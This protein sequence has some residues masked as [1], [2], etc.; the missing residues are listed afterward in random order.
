MTKIKKVVILSSIIFI[1]FSLKVFAVSEGEVITY[2]GITTTMPSI[3]KEGI[4]SED[5]MFKKKNSAQIESVNPS[6]AK[7]KA[8]VGASGT[9]EDISTLI[10]RFSNGNTTVVGI[11]VSSWQGDIDWKKVADSGVKFAII[12]CGYRGTSTG[13]LCQDSKFKKNIEGAINNGIFVGVYFY[14]T[15]INESEALQEAATVV[16]LVNGY[17]LKYPISYDFENFEVGG[18]RTDNLSKDQYNKNAK[19]FLDYVASKGYKGS[20]YGSS[21]YLS[22]NWNMSSF[23]NYDTWVAHYYVSNPTYAGKYQLWQYTDRGI[24]PGISEKVDVDIDY[25]YFANVEASVSYLGHIQGIGWENSWRYNGQTSGTTGQ[26][27]RVE[28][29]KIGLSN[30]K[31]VGTINYRSHIEG[32]GWE[33]SWRGDGQVTGTTGQGRRVEAIQVKLTNDMANNYDIYYRVHIEEYGW[34]GWAKNGASAGS[35]GLAKRIE[36]IE[37]KLV[38]KGGAAPGNTSNCFV[39]SSGLSYRAHVQD[40]GWQ[41]Y[42]SEGALSGTTGQSKRMESI[43]INLTT[44]QYSGGIQYRSHI[45]CI[46]WENGFKADGQLSGTTGEAKRLEALQIKLYGEIAN[47][48]DVYYRVHIQDFG[49]LGWAKNGES[50]GSEGFSKRMETYQIKLVPKGEK[51]PGST[52]NAFVK[53]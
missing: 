3:N 27:R 16:S 25:T 41:E 44:K 5:P 2:N 28:A 14:S 42:V 48:Y 12:R 52:A 49:W 47:Y 9:D 15:A 17:S 30:K 22:N 40:I 53:R 1:F 23:S 45:E 33:N 26:G 38:K 8:K 10:S 24:V 36:A 51:A 43:N 39:R 18:N 35:E 50:A 13:V 46:G 21:N 20:L 31:Y 4:E 11:D 29:L 37:I 19:V 7:V 32:I 34:L 6:S